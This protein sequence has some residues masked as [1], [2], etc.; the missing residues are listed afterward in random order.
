MCPT[1]DNT[2]GHTALGQELAVVVLRVVKEAAKAV[3]VGI[4]G[5]ILKHIRQELH[6]ILQRIENTVAIKLVLGE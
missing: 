4:L 1:V 2:T 6:F 3:E 5:N